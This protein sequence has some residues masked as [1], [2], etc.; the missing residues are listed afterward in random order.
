MPPE[1]EHIHLWNGE[2]GTEVTTH[3]DSYLSIMDIDLPDLSVSASRCMA[4]SEFYLS[5]QKNSNGYGYVFLNK[6]GDNVNVRSIA[7][8]SAS[9]FY[10]SKFSNSSCVMS[11]ADTLYD[12]GECQWGSFLCWRNLCKSTTSEGEY[13]SN[14]LE[15][16]Q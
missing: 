15:H 2:V 13:L 12:D 1:F 6:D 9:T 11:V 10:S 3:S 14:I 4:A 7:S 16:S 5:F 8:A